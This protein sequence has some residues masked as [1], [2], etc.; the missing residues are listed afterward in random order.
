MSEIWVPCLHRLCGASMHAVTGSPSGRTFRESPGESRSDDD[1][2]FPCL[3]PERCKH[4]TQIDSVVFEAAQNLA[5]ISGS[6][7]RLGETPISRVAGPHGRVQR[8]EIADVTRSPRSSQ[9]TLVTSGYFSVC[10]LATAACVVRS[11]RRVG[12]R[13]HT[14]PTSPIGRVK[15]SLAKFARI[16][17]SLPNPRTGGRLYRP[18]RPYRI[19][20]ERRL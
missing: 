17:A 12:S 20:V 14:K 9:L 18:C 11:L 3:P 7:S 6:P 5:R 4:G 13:R 19:F 2:W 1:P 15:S 8:T 10:L 16:A